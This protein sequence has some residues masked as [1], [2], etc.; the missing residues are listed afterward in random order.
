MHDGGTGPCGVLSGD[1]LL[2]RGR[3]L[4]HTPPPSLKRF[5]SSLHRCAGSNS[6][7]WMRAL[8]VFVMTPL[9]GSMCVIVCVCIRLYM[10]EFCCNVP[11]SSDCQSPR[12][13]VCRGFRALASLDPI[14]GRAWRHTY[15]SR[16][17]SFGLNSATTLTKKQGVDYH[18]CHADT[19]NSA[20]LDVLD[21]RKAQNTRVITSIAS[22]CVNHLFCMF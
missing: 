15:L 22:A 13:S 7:F 12:C 14:A 6:L 16:W 21:H 19:K 20:H 18:L 3:A 9:C 2:A 5:S 4:S 11:F 1:P 17:V 8:S 10:N